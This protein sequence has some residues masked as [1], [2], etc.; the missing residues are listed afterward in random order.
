MAIL[1]AVAPAKPGGDGW[2]LQNQ[3]NGWV[4][5]GHDAEVRDHCYKKKGAAPPAPAPA[6]P[7]PAGSPIALGACDASAKPAPRPARAWRLS[8][9]AQRPRL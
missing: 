3:G 5:E 6:S 7:I 9:G 1:A 4:I 2:T 8:W